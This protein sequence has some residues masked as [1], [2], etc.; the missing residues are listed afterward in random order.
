GTTNG[1]EVLYSSCNNTSPPTTPSFTTTTARVTMAPGCWLTYGLP[2]TGVIAPK[3]GGTKFGGYFTTV[4]ACSQ[5]CSNFYNYGLN[6][7]Y[8]FVYE[9]SNVGY[10]TLIQYPIDNI[11]TDPSSDAVLYTKCTPPSTITGVVTTTAAGTTTTV[12]RNPSNTTTAGPSG[13][14]TTV[15]PTV[16]AVTSTRAPTTTTAAPAITTTTVIT[17]KVPTTTTV[18]TTKTPTTTTVTTTKTPTTTT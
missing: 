3:N 1:D 9:P 10:C 4:D 5:L 13:T 15:P 12:A 17:T 14:T 2:V 18:T 6:P 7:C 8:G 16:S 11:A